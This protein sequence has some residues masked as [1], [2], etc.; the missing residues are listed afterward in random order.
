M[1]PVGGCAGFAG[2]L[3]PHHAAPSPC[4]YLRVH[5]CRV[6][7]WCPRGRR[8]CEG[9]A[10]HLVGG[11]AR[12]RPRTTHSDS[13]AVPLD[14]DDGLQRHH[15]KFRRSH[16]FPSIHR[17]SPLGLAY[18]IDPS[19]LALQVAGLHSPADRR[20]TRCV[21]AVDRSESCPGSSVDDAVTSQSPP[22]HLQSSAASSQCSRFLRAQELQSRSRCYGSLLS[23]RC[24]A[25][26]IALLARFAAPARLRGRCCRR[27]PRKLRPT[28]QLSSSARPS[29]SFAALD[30]ACACCVH[31]AHCHFR[32][33][34]LYTSPSP[35]D[36]TL[37]RMPSSA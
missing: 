29:H 27:H 31:H 16:A 2:V 3:P 36:A 8:H 12:N 10:R 18:Q 6:G 28:P 20:P 26:W 13:S 15:G 35:R 34:L 1:R 7:G 21:V 14:G 25:F 33:C 4:P 17:R 32:T 37:S 5:G 9:Y 30:V 11:W 19:C 22:L 23:E 24:D